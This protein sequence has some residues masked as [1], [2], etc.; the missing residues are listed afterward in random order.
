MPLFGLSEL[1]LVVLVVRRAARFYTEVIGLEVDQPPDDRWC[2][3]WC[4][5]PGA[6]P[7]LGLTTGPL[8]YGAAHCGGPTHFAFAVPRAYIHLEKKR[9][10]MRGLHVEGPVHFEA[11]DADSIYVSDPD[12]NRVELCGFP[13]LDVEPGFPLG[14]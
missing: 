1:S 13:Q 2:W 3:L 5:R 6:V 7:R 12:G 14:D 8:S 10:E 11:W 9:L 4:G